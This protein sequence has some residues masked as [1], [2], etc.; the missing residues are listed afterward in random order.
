[1]HEHTI[2]PEM[3]SMIQGWASQ[4]AYEAQKE[5][6]HSEMVLPTQKPGLFNYGEE[7][8]FESGE[9]EEYQGD[10]I[11]SLGHAELE[12]HRE[13]REYA[14]IAAYEMPLLSSMA[15]PSKLP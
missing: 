14:R 5:I 10:D 6:P 12:Q 4:A 13:L 11:N 9:D 1:M 7:E 3:D 8:V 15:L 2:S